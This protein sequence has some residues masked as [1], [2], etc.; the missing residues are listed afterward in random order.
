MRRTCEPAMI[1]EKQAKLAKRAVECSDHRFKNLYQQL[2]WRILIEHAANRVLARPGSSTA[3]ID[4]K[5]R[6]GFKKEYERHL[7]NLISQLKNRTYEPQ[8]VKRTYIPKE[9]GKQRSLGIPVL[10]D[11]IVQEALRMMLDPIFE[12]DFQ[13]HS[14]GFRKGRCTM[15]AIAVL[16]PLFNTSSKHYYV[17][18]GDI[19]NFFEKVHH[20]KLMTLLR[21]RIADERAAV[22]HF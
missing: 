8:P 15:D 12:S 2:H 1:T 7:A 22:C 6:Y 5:T 10:Y 20:E 13:H 11:R 17:I 21:K 18:E 14:Y 16:M 4:G 19:R 9:S 3:G